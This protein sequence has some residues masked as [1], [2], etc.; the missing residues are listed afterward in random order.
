[1]YVCMYVCMYVYIYTL[2]FEVEKKVTYLFPFGFQNKVL[3]KNSLKY[4]KEDERFFPLSFVFTKEY[5]KK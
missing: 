4:R 2:A 1:M 3:H 5:R